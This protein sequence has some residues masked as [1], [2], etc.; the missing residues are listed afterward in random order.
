MITP[1]PM[2]PDQEERVF[3][4]ICEERFPIHLFYIVLRVDT[5]SQDT[6]QDPVKV[7]NTNFAEL[8]SQIDYVLLVKFV[9]LNMARNK[10]PLKYSI[11]VVCIKM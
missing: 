3:W 4:D 2:W 10:I 1:S 11:L 8:L 7:Q 6:K 5:V 9:K